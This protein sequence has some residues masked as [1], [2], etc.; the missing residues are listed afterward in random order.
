[1]NTMNTCEEYREAI[2]AE[3]SFDG[4]AAH[5]SQC[6]SCQAFRAE[7]LALDLKISSA[8]AISVP[9]FKLPELPELD[10]S[11]VTAMPLRRFAQPAWL[12]VAATVT[13]AAFIGFGMFGSDVSNATLAEQILVHID[14]EPGAFRVVDEAVTDKRLARV[15]P[16]NIA[17]LNHSAG[18]ITYARSCLINGREVPHLVIQGEFGPITILLMPG[19]KITG[20]QTIEGENVHGIILPVGD[21]S[22]AI[23][24]EVGEHLERIEKQVMNSVTWST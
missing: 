14:H 10:T 3:P 1:M 11:K 20:A 23:I 2:A 6:A 7:M 5:L 19:E 24:G 4:G 9:E 17:T 18:L 16:A 8:L 22:I 15:V 21:G 13:L 12:A